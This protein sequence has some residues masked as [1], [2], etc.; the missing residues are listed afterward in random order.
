M[1]VYIRPDGYKKIKAMLEIAVCRGEFP[2]FCDESNLY[3]SDSGEIVTPACLV[4][5]THSEWDE[6]HMVMLNTTRL[7]RLKKMAGRPGWWHASL[8]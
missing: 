6:D 2:D 3:W 5:L 4:L 8:A 7:I 1:E